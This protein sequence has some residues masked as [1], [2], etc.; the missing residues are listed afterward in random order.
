MPTPIY[1]CNVRPYPVGN[2]M[3]SCRLHSCVKVHTNAN[4]SIGGPGGRVPLSLF[5]G[6][7]HA[8]R[9]PKVRHHTPVH[10]RSCSLGRETTVL[11]ISLKR[12]KVTLR[13][14]RVLIVVSAERRSGK[15]GWRGRYCRRCPVSGPD[16]LGYQSS[17]PPMCVTWNSSSLGS[18]P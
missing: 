13:M 1:A 10:W 5:D 3:F 9:G 17:E 18:F 14:N 16:A 4:E 6:L 15:R 12:R 2:M 8:G 11:T 7:T